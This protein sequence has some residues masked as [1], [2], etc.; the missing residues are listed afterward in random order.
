MYKNW[1]DKKI[2]GIIGRGMGWGDFNG[3]NRRAFS[4]FC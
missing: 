4:G 3:I 1:F 2:S